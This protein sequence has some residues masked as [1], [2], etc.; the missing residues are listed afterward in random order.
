MAEDYADL[1]VIEGGLHRRLMIMVRMVLVGSGGENLS[2]LIR[3]LPQPFN[4]LLSF[5]LRIIRNF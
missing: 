1:R 4:D 3:Q 2:R 5:S